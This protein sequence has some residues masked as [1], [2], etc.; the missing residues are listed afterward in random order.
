MLPEEKETIIICNDVDDTA[1]IYTYD[2]A[3]QAHIEKVLGIKAWRTEGSAK[4]YE[5]PKKYLR[6]PR[7]P[8]EKRR[9]AARKRIAANPHQ[10]SPKRVKK[11]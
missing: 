8:S 4:D 6:W 1:S 5:I 10:F 9:E 3:F 2:K 11:A 7:K